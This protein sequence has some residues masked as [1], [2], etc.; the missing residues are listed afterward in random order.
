LE[1]R[2]L[3]PIKKP[4][5]PGVYAVACHVKTEVR[6]MTEEVFKLDGPIMQAQPEIE[7]GHGKLILIRK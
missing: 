4:L 5:K 3:H 6:I 2:F 1:P 7:L